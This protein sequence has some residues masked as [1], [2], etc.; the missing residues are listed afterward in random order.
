A[1]R[2]AIA[3]TIEDWLDW[4]AEE[5]PR[6]V[7]DFYVQI[8]LLATSALRKR[9]AKHALRPEGAEERVQAELD[10]RAAQEAASDD[11]ATLQQPETN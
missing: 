10:K 3:D 7:E 1:A 11:G 5:E 6:A 2:A 8:E 9:I 4:L